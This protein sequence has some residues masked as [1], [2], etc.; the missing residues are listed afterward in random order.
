MHH[1]K[2]QAAPWPALARA[3]KQTGR[4][5]DEVLDSCCC[6]ADAPAATLAF[7]T[8]ALSLTRPKRAELLVVDCGAA[9]CS[10]Y[11][12]ITGAPR[13]GAH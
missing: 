4:A 1:Y 9:S 2:T 3:E 10:P 12:V 5:T 11:D 8:D 13:P 6:W 7:V